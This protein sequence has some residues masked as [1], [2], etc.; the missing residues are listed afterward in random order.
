MLKSAWTTLSPSVKNIIN[1]VGFRTFF[2]TL[3]NQETYE[4]KDLQ[5]LLVLAERFWDTICT[6]HFPGFG[7]VMLTPYDFSV[8][9]GLRFGGEGILVNGF[10]TSTELKKLLGVVPSRMRSNDIPL[11]WFCDNIPNVRLWQR[12]LVCSCFFLLGLSC[13]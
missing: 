12:V 13:V 8:I 1:E 4:Y 5:L 11:S 10:L 3:L 9:T 6:F 7:E 2:K